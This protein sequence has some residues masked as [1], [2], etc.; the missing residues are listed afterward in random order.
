LLIPW[1]DYQKLSVSRS[2]LPMTPEKELIERILLGEKSLFELIVRR[3]N[4]LLYKVGRSY[5]L[6]HEDTQDLM[7]ETF[8]DAY[9]YLP[10][11]QGRSEFKT[12]IIRIMMNHGHRKNENSGYTY[13]RRQG[14]R[15]NAST[16]FSEPNHDLET[17]MYTKELG[18]LIVAALQRRPFADRLPS[19]LREIIGMTD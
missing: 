4:P 8:I 10:T 13:E 7:Q 14:A 9:K 2:N 16:I 11:F 5:N 19:S 6:N 1:L 15:E 12:W 17:I 3:F 18:Q